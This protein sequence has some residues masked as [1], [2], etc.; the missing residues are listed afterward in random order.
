MFFS[1]G[2]LLIGYFHR[3]HSDK[4]GVDLTELSPTFLKKLD[5]IRGVVADLLAEP[6]FLGGEVVMG[7]LVLRTLM[8]RVCEVLNQQGKSIIPQR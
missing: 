8:T 1:L 4:D 2:L 7:G 3:L 5:T 6:H